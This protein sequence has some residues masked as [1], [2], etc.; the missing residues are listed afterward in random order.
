MSKKY[1]Q[2]LVLISG[3][4]FLAGCGQQS[5]TANQPAVENKTEQPA[6]QPEADQQAQGSKVLMQGMVFDP[7]ELTVKVGTTVKW[8]NMDPSNHQ[9]KSPLF[10]SSVLSTAKSFEFT[11][12][13]PG[14]FNYSCAIHPK[15]TGKIIVEP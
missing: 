13:T 4:F 9:I 10:G 1:F 3:V 11:F 14:T 2:G 8:V 6:A 7:A 5:Q 12:K 15:M